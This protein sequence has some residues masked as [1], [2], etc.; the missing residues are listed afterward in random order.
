[1][2][3][4]SSLSILLLLKQK[5]K[6]KQNTKIKRIFPSTLAQYTS[7]I[8]VLERS[9]VSNY[10]P[11]CHFLSYVV[12][13]V[14]EKAWISLKLSKLYYQCKQPDSILEEKNVKKYSFVYVFKNPQFSQ[15]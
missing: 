4:H 12:K 5:H 3:S 9:A 15:I 14:K 1:M 2:L 8:A 11:F 13:A 7:N 6:Q 10:I